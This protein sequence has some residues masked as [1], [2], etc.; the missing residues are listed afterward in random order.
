MWYAV[1]MP[2][3]H[4]GKGFP[5]GAACASKVFCVSLLLTVAGCVLPT[6]GGDRH[7]LWHV[8]VQDF[9]EVQGKESLL[10]FADSVEKE[11]TNGATS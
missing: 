4:P 6:P 1:G 2:D 11:W 3:L 8:S 10:K 7:W 5:I 9:F